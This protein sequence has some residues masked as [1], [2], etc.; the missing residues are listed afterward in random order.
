MCLKL[1]LPGGK[2]RACELQKEEN[3]P[4][5]KG[6]KD[7]VVKTKER[8]EK[9]SLPPPEKKGKEKK[10]EKVPV[11][12]PSQKKEKGLPA[13][14]QKKGKGGGGNPSLLLPPEQ[15]KRGGGKGDTGGGK[16]KGGGV[17]GVTRLAL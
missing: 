12:H 7:S 4:L 2:K 17:E 11:G 10:G 14:V 5:R 16:K 13:R 8:R 15:K 6:G 9:A 3:H 1:L